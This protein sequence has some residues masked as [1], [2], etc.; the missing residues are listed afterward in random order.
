[1]MELLKD[2]D[3]AEDLL[4]FPGVVVHPSLDKLSIQIRASTKPFKIGVAH[5]ALKRWCGYKDRNG[6]EVPALRRGF[7]VMRV[8]VLVD[9]FEA[10]D[11]ERALISTWKHS[12]LC[13]NATKGGEN[14]NMEENTS[15]YFI[16]VTFRN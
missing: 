6:K 5:D 12:P 13:L 15:P 8:A 10:S 11:A 4:N 1:M 2:Y 7:K 14:I 9:N 16:Y 3:S